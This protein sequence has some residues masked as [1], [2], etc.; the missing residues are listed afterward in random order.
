MIGSHDYQ[1]R[2]RGAWSAVIKRVKD[3]MVLDLIVGLKV[4]LNKLTFLHLMDH[5]KVFSGFISQ[6]NFRPLVIYNSKF[7]S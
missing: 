1:V 4:L 2:H 6:E 3:L 5:Y 7:E